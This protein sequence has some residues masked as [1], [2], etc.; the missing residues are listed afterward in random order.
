MSDDH[1]GRAWGI[2]AYEGNCV[3]RE[4]LEQTLEWEQLSQ[5]KSGY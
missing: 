4:E 2:G 1:E 3:R 5:E